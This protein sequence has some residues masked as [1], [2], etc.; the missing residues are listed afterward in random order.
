MAHLIEATFVLRNIAPP[1]G[2]SV[3]DIYK[4]FVQQNPTSSA[5]EDMVATTLKRGAEKGVFLRC[6][7]PALS[8]K[9]YY[10]F[11]RHMAVVNNANRQYGIP[12]L[13]DLTT[14]GSAYATN[15]FPLPAQHP[16]VGLAGPNGLSCDPNPDNFFRQTALSTRVMASQAPRECCL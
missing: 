3:A 12:L 1:Q 11:N 10:R 15:N 4:T 7:Y 8:G 5:T 6:E 16:V 9:Q 14:S 13:M 2:S